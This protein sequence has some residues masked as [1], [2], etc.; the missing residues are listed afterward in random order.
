MSCLQ[1]PCQRASGD[2][3]GMH[4]GI[5]WNVDL[6]EYLAQSLG[7]LSDAVHQQSHGA[8]VL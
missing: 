6:H 2:Q 5:A 1:C 8:N 7:Q 3:F 4:S